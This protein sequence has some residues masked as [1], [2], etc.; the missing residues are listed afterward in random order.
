MYSAEPIVQIVL[1][2]YETGSSRPRPEEEARIVALGVIGFMLC[3]Q[4]D[5]S[6][7]ASLSKRSRSTTST[8]WRKLSAD[9]G[10]PRRF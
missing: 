8:S 9:G 2:G 7:R 6:A 10:Y 3:R 5:V 4:E 1:Q